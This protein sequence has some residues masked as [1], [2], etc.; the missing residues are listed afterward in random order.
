VFAR[1]QP[2][3]KLRITATLQRAGEVVAVTGDGTNDAPALR[4]ADVGV[5]M[6]RGGTDLAREASDVILLDDNLQSNTRR[7]NAIARSGFA[8]MSSQCRIGFAKSGPGV[9][10]VGRGP[11]V[12]RHRL[13]AAGRDRALVHGEPA[14]Q[15]A[16]AAALRAHGLDPVTPSRGQAVELD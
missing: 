7:Y 15:D 2:E 5:A 1:V 4:Q 6:G 14:A 9:Q 12:V 3:H 13:D 8:T 10:T 16:L 11:A